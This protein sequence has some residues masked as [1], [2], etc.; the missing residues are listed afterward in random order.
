MQI[1]LW[2]FQPTL[3]RHSVESTGS[4]VREFNAYQQYRQ[5][6][7]SQAEAHSSGHSE[8]DTCAPKHHNPIIEAS[9]SGRDLL[10][11]TELRQRVCAFCTCVCVLFSFFSRKFGDNFRKSNFHF[12]GGQFALHATKKNL[13]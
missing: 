12:P 3:R 10:A 8:R 6:M 2:T 9:N 11:P 5:Q 4:A 13:R 7:Q 1:L